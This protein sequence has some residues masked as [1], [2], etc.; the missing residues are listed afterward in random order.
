MRTNLDDPSAQE[1]VAV[2]K[3]L[4]LS[5]NEEALA[6]LTRLSASTFDAYRLLDRF[7]ID[8]PASYPSHDGGA[9]PSPQQNPY[10]AWSRI[11]DVRDNSDGPLKGM[12]V[13]LKDSI[14]LAGVPMSAGN[15]LIDGFIPDFD[16]TVVQRLLDAGARIAG[17]AVCENLC[18]SGSS[19]TAASGPVHNPHRVGYSA[20][21]SSSGCAV[22]VAAR[23][24]EAAIGGDQGGSIRVPA[25]LCGVYGMKATYGLVP[26]TGAIPIEPTID[27][28]GPMTLTVEDN[29][30][31]LEVIAG[32]DGIDFRQR[33]VSAKRYTQA[34]GQSISGLRVAVLAEGFTLPG[35]CSAVGQCVREA[36]NVIGRLGAVVEDASIPMHVQ[37]SQLLRPIL[38]EGAIRTLF[39]GDAFGTGRHDLYP[40]ALMDRFRAWRDTADELPAPAKVLL[41]AG[42]CLIERNGAHYYA[43]ALAVGRMLRCSY[44]LLLEKYDLILMPTTP[45]TAQ[46]LPPRDASATAQISAAFGV[47]VN[48]APFNVTGHPSMSIPCGMVDG[49]PV[50][51]MLVG[52]HFD[53]FTIYRAA[54][55]FEQAFG[56]PS[57]IN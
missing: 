7:Q 39:H 23:E 42:S 22:L 8:D 28:L 45:R 17:K 16:A 31:V 52:R 55:A 36:A 12:R 13:A 44:D 11:T 40:L 34:L 32:D 20:G 25:A 2:S 37:A 1:L 48:A 47:S 30:K 43:K 5:L 19:F 50:G 38:L 14:F 6:E 56:V 49:M 3:T 35:S 57:L 10:G 29:A 27:H 41:L 4:G 15:G 53:E 18:L 24:V 51:M 46:P 21:G 26:Y 54:H 33:G 9:A